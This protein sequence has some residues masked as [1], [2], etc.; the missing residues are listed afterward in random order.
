MTQASSGVHRGNQ[1]SMEYAKLCM[2]MQ[3]GKARY[4]ADPRVASV[5]DGSG[6][7]CCMPLLAVRARDHLEGPV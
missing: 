6:E 5:Y 3:L 2:S 1:T 4:S 7:A